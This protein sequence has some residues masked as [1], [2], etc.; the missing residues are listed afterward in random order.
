MGSFVSKQKT[1]QPQKQSNQ[2]YVTEL[3]SKKTSRRYQKPADAIKY[4]YVHIGTKFSDHNEGISAKLLDCEQ[5]KIL[6]EIL[7]LHYKI[8]SN[9]NFD[10][11][12]IQ[13]AMDEFFYLLQFDDNISF[14]YIHNYFNISCKLNTCN[15]M[16][17]NYRNR[18]ADEPNVIQKS[19]KDLVKMQL[20]D[21]IHCFY[22]HSYDIGHKLSSQELAASLTDIKNVKPDDDEN[23]QYLLNKQILKIK[24]ILLKKRACN[25]SSR[26]RNMTK[27]T[28]LSSESKQNQD[29]NKNDSFYHFGYEF[30]YG[31][32][33]EYKHEGSIQTRPKYTTFKQELTNNSIAKLNIEQYN[34]EYHKAEIHFNSVHCRKYQSSIGNYMQKKKKKKMA[35]LHILSLMVYCNYD[36]LQNRFSETFRINNGRSQSN[37][38]F[39]GKYLKM[40][41]Q[42]FGTHVS[43]GNIRQF[44]HGISRE[45]Y[46]RTY[47]GHPDGVRIYGPLST[48]SQF[49]VAVNFASNGMVVTFGKDNRRYF[50]PKCYSVS[51]LSDFANESEYLF[52]QN[53]SLLKICNVLN[54]VHGYEYKIILSALYIINE[55]TVL[56]HKCV[57]DIDDFMKRLITSII[58]NQ[59][60]LYLAQYQGFTSLCQYAKTVINLYFAGR[61]NVV[62]QYG[63]AENTNTAFLSALL[64]DSNTEEINWKLLN[65]LF[66]NML[67][68]NISWAPIKSNTLNV[69]YVHLRGGSTLRKIV[70]DKVY[71]NQI[72]DNYGRYKQMFDSVGFVLHEGISFDG[73][74]YVNIEQKASKLKLVHSINVEVSNDE[75]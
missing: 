44:H 73:Y 51:W 40:A 8:N 59:L 64:F 23:T 53:N 65:T 35:L 27:Y 20:L 56:S 74:S 60:S 25:P 13:S 18:D 71:F 2:L 67:S 68:I 22:M 32:Q 43:E 63:A 1:D 49:E 69:I 30:F 37:F 24:D 9:A 10:Q 28:M 6:K 62:L 41:V 55:V 36:M 61:K 11:I 46:F 45:L 29:E 21:K 57:D 4:D 3:E 14:E 54:T 66:P 12:N 17:R 38:Y 50:T 47:I 31:Y 58:H 7:H 39:F 5:L 16:K 33:G 42:Q 15:C 19:T 52:H 26:N 75:P 48:S 72:I 34:N 70:L